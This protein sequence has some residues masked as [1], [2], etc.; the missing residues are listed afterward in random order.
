M[1]CGAPNCFCEHTKVIDDHIQACLKD[2]EPTDNFDQLRSA[3][4]R[5]VPQ[6][7]HTATGQIIKVAGVQMVAIVIMD[8][9][10]ASGKFTRHLNVASTL[11][12]VTMD[13]AYRNMKQMAPTAE[14]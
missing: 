10:H 13:S 9:I 5:D 6:E 8:S 3:C 11:A 1:S 2:M 14:A 12:A 7:V 4:T